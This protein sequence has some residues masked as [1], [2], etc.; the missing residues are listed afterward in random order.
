MSQRRDAASYAAFALV[1]AVFGT[2]FLGIKLGVEAGAP[3]FLFAGIR[4]AI[5]GTLLGAGL[6]AS[7]RATPRSLA[8]LAPRAAILSSLYVVV[9]FGASFWAERTIDSATA[10]QI[11]SVGPVAAAALSALFL[12]KRLGLAHAAG[13]ALGF[14]GVAL[15]VRA[16]AGAPGPAGS[17]GLASLAADPAALAA[18]LVMLAGAL[19]FAG[20]QVLYKAL[21]TER[22]DPFQVSAMNMAIGGLGLLALSAAF[23]RDPFPASAQALGALVYLIVV[24]SIVGHSVNLWLIKRSGPVFASSW[25]YVSPVIATMVGFL[26]LGENAGPGALAGTALTLAGVALI[27]RAESAGA[28]AI[29]SLAPRRSDAS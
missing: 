8:A 22:D 16:S 12:K 23:E 17:G 27:A 4:F 13:M 3:P 14:A 9:N 5:A 2:T 29:G 6:L 7:G 18:S 20:A 15:I 21:F 26:V 25:S 24:G 10:A 11:N 19:G 28:P 1:C